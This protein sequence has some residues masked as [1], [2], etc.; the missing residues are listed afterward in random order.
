MVCRKPGKKIQ[1]SQTFSV[2]LKICPPGTTACSWPVGN[3]VYLPDDRPD[4]CTEVPLALAHQSQESNLFAAF[5]TSVRRPT[6]AE[7][8]ADP[9]K[10]SVIACHQL[11]LSISRWRCFT[12]PVRWHLLWPLSWV[13]AWSKGCCSFSPQTSETNKSLFVLPR[14]CTDAAVP[15]LLQVRNYSKLQLCGKFLK[16]WDNMLPYILFFGTSCFERRLVPSVLCTY[17]ILS[18]IYSGSAC[19]L[20]SG[21]ITFTQSESAVTWL[22]WYNAFHPSV[23]LNYFIG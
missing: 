2:G 22:K 20:I 21:Y 8:E 5:H 4:H 14:I 19:N 16:T 17:L 10:F 15:L 13:W 9:E 11:S 18:G 7:P 6:Q 23:P 12:S 1:W 3:L